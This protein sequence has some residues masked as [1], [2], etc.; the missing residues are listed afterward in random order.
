MNDFILADL[1]DTEAMARGKQHSAVRKAAR[2]NRGLKVSFAEANPT[3]EFFRDDEPLL[4]ALER[5]KTVKMR[6]AATEQ[7]RPA[8]V[9]KVKN[10]EK[11]FKIKAKLAIMKLEDRWRR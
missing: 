5:E 8:L 11:R 10:V 7:D 9:K 3:K 4:V 6:P 1:A 2:K